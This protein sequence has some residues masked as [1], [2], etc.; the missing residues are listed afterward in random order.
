MGEVFKA[1]DN[2]YS[3][4]DKEKHLK[5]Y[6]AQVTHDC[7]SLHGEKGEFPCFYQSRNNKILLSLWTDLQM[8][9]M[10]LFMSKT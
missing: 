8:V 7:H 2:M 4:L 3:M 6:T 5:K 9:G 1:L 10:L